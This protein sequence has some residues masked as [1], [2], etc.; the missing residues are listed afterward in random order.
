MTDGPRTCHQH[1][2]DLPH[3]QSWTTCRGC[4]ALRVHDWHYFFCRRL[5]D[6][7]KPDEWPGEGWR[8]LNMTVWKHERPVPCGLPEV[9]TQETTE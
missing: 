9:P 5:G 4:P 2:R 3:D 1:R 7:G 6:Q 8:R